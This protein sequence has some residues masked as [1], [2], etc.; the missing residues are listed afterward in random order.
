MEEG[1]LYIVRSLVDELM[2]LHPKLFQATVR[3]IKAFCTCLP[4]A[5]VINQK[6]RCSRGQMNLLLALKRSLKTLVYH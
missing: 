2:K 1:E 6:E 5:N 4:A 3:A